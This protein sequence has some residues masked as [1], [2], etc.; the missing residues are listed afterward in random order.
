MFIS[1][2]AYWIHLRLGCVVEKVNAY[3]NCP[4]EKAHIKRAT[5]TYL[6]LNLTA[7]SIR[8]HTKAE[9]M[10]FPE[11]NVADGVMAVALAIAFTLLVVVV[12]LKIICEGGCRRKKVAPIPPV[13]VTVV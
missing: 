5:R 13:E 11:D 12:L 7:T 10:L 4:T 8:E 9:D 6:R 1:A 2:R 3:W